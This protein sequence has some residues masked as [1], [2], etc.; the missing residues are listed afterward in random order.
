MNVEERRR[1]AV[2]PQVKR[3]RRERGLTLATWQ[4]GAA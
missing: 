2:G 1:P 4:S 3:W